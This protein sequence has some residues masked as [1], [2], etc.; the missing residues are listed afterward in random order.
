MAHIEDH[1]GIAPTLW[2]NTLIYVWFVRL[3]CFIGLHSLNFSLIL[4]YI[5]IDMYD[6]IAGIV[7][8]FLFFLITHS[9]R[10]RGGCRHI[11]NVFLGSTKISLHDLQSKR[12][13]Y[14]IMALYA[15]SPWVQPLSETGR[16]SSCLFKAL[17]PLNP[18]QTSASSGANINK[19]FF[20]LFFTQ[21]INS[22]NTS[23]MFELKSDLKDKNG[24]INKPWNNLHNL[25]T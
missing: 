8:K 10:G 15:G 20:Y 1:E 22:S 16:V 11:I 2:W 12:L 19:H 4:Y 7:T 13:I 17:L 9:L 21:N 6:A 24:Q 5:L 14:F 25:I 3:A 18:R 23:Y